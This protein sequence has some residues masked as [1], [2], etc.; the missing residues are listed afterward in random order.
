VPLGGDPVLVNR[1][2]DG[3]LE[4]RDDLI[5]HGGSGATLEMREFGTT[6]LQNSLRQA[7]FREVFFL[8]ENLPPIGV[9]FDH[10]VSQPLIAR[11]EPF[12]M[13]RCGQIQLAAEWRALR[14][15]AQREQKRAEFA[16]GAGSNGGGVA[17]AGSGEEARGGAEVPGPGLNP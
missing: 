10:D 1:R 5:F 4:V 8:T 17:L 3:S 15:Q 7:G 16:G 2:R 13:D 12:V 14:E 9:L 6:A 11:K